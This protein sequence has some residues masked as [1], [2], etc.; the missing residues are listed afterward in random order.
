MLRNGKRNTL[1]KLTGI[2]DIGNGE[3]CPYCDIII[4]EDIDTYDHLTTQHQDELLASLFPV[5]SNAHAEGDKSP[6]NEMI[7]RS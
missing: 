2:L 3:K 5:K 7:K 1:P 6:Q 4:T